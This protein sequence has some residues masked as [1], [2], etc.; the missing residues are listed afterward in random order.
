MKRNLL[1]ALL[2][3]LPLM[4][5]GQAYAGS[6]SLTLNRLTLINVP[7]AAGLWQH[8]GG[9]VFKGAV[10]VGNYALT[11]RVTN[12]GTAAQNTAMVTLTIFFLGVSPPENITFQGSHSFS[13]GRSIGSISAASIKYDWIRDG[14]YA[15]S[16]GATSTLLVTWQGSSQ[17]SLP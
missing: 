17:L 12:G 13:T 15:G 2:L 9:R 16:F 8:E 4:M 6:V 14:S 10:Q 3:M 11:R 7:D 1:K 5:V